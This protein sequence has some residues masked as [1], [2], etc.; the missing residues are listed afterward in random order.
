MGKQFGGKKMTIDDLAL[1]VGRGFDRVENR[2]DGLEAK[3]DRIDRRC[4][5]LQT[6]IG[7]IERRCDGL[8]AQIA[9]VDRRIDDIAFNKVGYKELDLI[10]A[11]IRNKLAL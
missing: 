8:Q 4:D 1:I 2:M 7:G 6:Q 9:G 11:P 5:G 3:I 10:L